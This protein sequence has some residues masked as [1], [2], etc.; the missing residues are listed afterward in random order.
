MSDW[1]TLFKEAVAAS[2]ITRV[3][4]QL[5]ISRTAASLV[6]GEKYPA[7]TDKIAA[8]VLDV[9]ARLTC[10]HTNVEISHAECRALSI[11]AVPTSSPQAMRH[12]RACQSCPHKG[13]K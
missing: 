9:F 5:G 7:K 1:L 12:W 8:K 2:S 6:L 4:E 11:S 10:P 13:G 3:A